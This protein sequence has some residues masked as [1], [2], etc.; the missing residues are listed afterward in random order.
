MKKFSPRPPDN[1]ENFKPEG[2]SPK[3]EGENSEKKET[4]KLSCEL[5]ALELLYLWNA[6][7]SCDQDHLKSILEG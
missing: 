2:E 5:F 1:E 6:L 4:D 7:P 3:L